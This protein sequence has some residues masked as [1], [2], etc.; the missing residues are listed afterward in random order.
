MQDLQSKREEQEVVMRS[1]IDHFEDH[2]GRIETGWQTDEYGDHTP[3]QIVRFVGGPADGYITFATLGLSNLALISP[4]SGK[5]IR[6]ELVMVAPVEL[7]QSNV[8]GIL[9]QVAREAIESG[10]PYLRGQVIGPR[11]QL[12]K[13]SHLEALYV[14]S[15]VCFP[16]S[17]ATFDGEI[18]GRIVLVWLIPITVTEARY[19]HDRG[20]DTFELRLNEFDVDLH[21]VFREELPLGR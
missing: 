14:T 18:I 4:R 12:F 19:I 21:D 6:H 10:H 16:D 11:G 2:L 5:A 13:G 8:P 20:W 15:P 1:L 7:R 3:F 17:F 9:Q